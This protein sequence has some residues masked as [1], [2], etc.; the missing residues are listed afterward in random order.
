[1]ELQPEELRDGDQSAERCPYVAGGYAVERAAG[2]GAA[3][4][5]LHCEAA[6]DSA[7]TG[8][9]D[10]GSA[11]GREGWPDAAEADH[12]FAAGTM[13]RDCD[14]RSVSAAAEEVSGEFLGRGQAEA[15]CRDDEGS[16]RGC[17]SGVSEVCG[18]SAR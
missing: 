2:F 17:A 7:G 16:E 15:D 11:A 4:R 14:G 10:G 3:L 18:V 1:R 13:R 8:P 6:P 12:S 9:D 5:G